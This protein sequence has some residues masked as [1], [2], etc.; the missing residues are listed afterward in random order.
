MRKYF[1]KKNPYQIEI[2]K[3]QQTKKEL[4]FTE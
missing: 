2:I 4:L 3:G 1:I